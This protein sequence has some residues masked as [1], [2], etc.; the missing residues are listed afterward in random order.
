MRMK[1]RISSMGKSLLGA[2]CLLS[3]C[4]VTYSCSD[5]FDLD[6]KSPSFLGASIYDELKNKQNFTTVIRL[7]DDLGYKDVMSKTGS[8]T[9]FVADDAAYA[10]FFAH[11]DWKDGAGNPVDSYEKLSTNQKRLLLNGSMLNNAYVLEMLTTIEGPVKNLCL[12]QLS[13]MSATDSVP[14]WPKSSLPHNLNKGQLDAEGNVTNQ[15]KLFWEKYRNSANL[16]I[17]MAIDNTTPMMTHFLEGQMREKKITHE[18]VSFILNLRDQNSPQY[19]SNADTENRSYIYGSRILEQDVTCL[20]GYYHVLDSVL[21]TPPNMAEVIRTNGE[22]NLFSA[23][24]ERFSAP[25]YDANLTEQYKALHSIEADSIF[26][27]IYIS[28]RS[29]LGAVTTDPDGESLGD[30]PSLSYDPGWN[31]YSVNMSSKEQDMAAMFVPSDQAMK[32]YFVRGGGA[33]LIERYGTLENTEENLLENLY[34]IPLN[35]IKPLVANMMKDSFNES[36]PSKYLT[37]MNDAQ[38]PMFSS[39]SY[40]SIDAYKAG[41]KKVLLANNGVVY[42][43]N[44]LVSPATYA[45]VMSPVLYNEGTQVMNTVIHADDAYTTVNYANAPLRKFYS[46]YLLSMQSSFSLF[47]P[48]DKGLKTRGYMDPIAYATHAAAQRKYWTFEP[49]AVT[50]KNGKYVAVKSLG[51]LMSD[52]NTEMNPAGVTPKWESPANGNIADGANKNAKL[53]AFMLCEMV[54]HHILVHENNDL[55]GVRGERQWYISRNGAPVYVKSRGGRDGVGMVVDGGMQLQ[56]NTDQYDKNDFDCTVEQVYDMKPTST[57]YGNGKTYFLDRPMQAALY[58]TYALLNKNADAYGEFF[59]LC[60]SL[61][62]S[63]AIGL[64]ESLFRGENVS[65]SDWQNEATKYFIFADNGTKAP[66]R[67]APTGEKLIRFFNS[68]RYT[69]YVPSNQAVQNAIAAGLPTIDDIEQYVADHSADEDYETVGKPK[70]QAMLTTLVNFVKYHFAD[71]SL[72]VDNCTDVTACQS[73]CTDGKTNG[74]VKL[75]VKQTPGAMTL[76]DAAGQSCSVGMPNNICAREIETDGAASSASSIKASSYVTIHALADDKYMLFSPTIK[77]G[78]AEAW[79]DVPT[80][81]AFAKRYRMKK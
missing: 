78:F 26:K 31:A 52:E 34:Q 53:K 70:A 79:K 48:T 10:R 72:F 3:A 14:F 61:S 59:K 67:P 2:V 1:N 56:F 54:D 35:I 18:D 65:E 71:Q 15:D 22:T 23:M 25:Y 20:N 62:T 27:K 64:V 17:Y 7:I 39:T 74:F 69:V 42:V 73:A 33:I 50:Q 60:N 80:A 9:L 41:I 76:V 40:P 36:V 19:W 55:E 51:Y 8:K 77:N 29:S 30:F 5:D 28:Q 32:D 24:L 57:D 68:Y 81:Q 44:N 47:V 66:A 4:G 49:E 63:K 13:A 11:N 37:I 75:T 58:T 16:G 38:D 46:T 45:S 43:M 12:R 21:V 6:E